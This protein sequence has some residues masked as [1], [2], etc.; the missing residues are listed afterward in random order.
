MSPTLTAAT[1]LGVIL[2]TAAYMVPEQAKGRAVDKRADIWAFGCVLF[3]LLTGR[4]AFEGED[5]SDTLAFVLTKEPP[6]DALPPATPAVVRR[7]LHRC[8]DKD[9]KRRLRDIGEARIAIDEAAQ[10]GSD[11][12]PAAVARPHA[13]RAWPWAAAV[14]LLTL[15][16]LAAS[17]LRPRV[18]P[19]QDRVRVPPA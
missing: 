16:V 3:E 11:K 1:Q 6:W 13:R 15:A 8:L 4:R 9:P 14:A 12:E 7:L 2:G 10:P 5:I 18:E 19:P 17:I